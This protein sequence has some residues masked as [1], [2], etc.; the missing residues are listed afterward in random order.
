[1]K[2]RSCRNKTSC[3]DRSPPFLH[4][5]DPNT[6]RTVEDALISILSLVDFIKDG[7][8]LND[9]ATQQACHLLDIITHGAR[10]NFSGDGH[11]GKHVP[12]LVGSCSG[13]TESMIPLLT[14]SNED[15]VR[16]ALR[17]LAQTVT[18][19]S[20]QTRFA[21]LETGFFTLLPRTFYEQEVH[22]MPSSKLF[23][24]DIV[25]RFLWDSHPDYAHEILQSGQLSIDVVQQTFL[26]KFIHPIKPF[27]EYICRHRRRIPDSRKHRRFP[28]LLAKILEL[29]LLLEEMMQFVLSSSFF[30]AFTDC[31]HFYET[32][33]STSHLLQS[34]VDPLSDWWKDCPVFQK[35]RQRIVAKLCEEGVSDEIELHMRC[36]G[37]DECEHDD[38]F[39]GAVLIGLWGGNTPFFMPHW[40]IS[41]K[42][43]KLN[44]IVPESVADAD[45]AWDCTTPSNSP[46]I[47]FT[48]SRLEWDD[49][50]LHCAWASLPALNIGDRAPNFVL[51]NQD[52]QEI[53]FKDQLGDGPVVVFVCHNGTSLHD[54]RMLRGFR[55]FKK[56]FIAQNATVF[57][58]S[59]H[60]EA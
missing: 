42:H 17:L 56:L 60:T 51:K 38:V 16:S 29:S 45:R 22:L 33:R 24:M 34:V 48:L 18:W 57:R 55:F 8:N 59:A 44:R 12:T 53:S 27:L 54:K 9:I 19:G 36:E 41:R 25:H 20:K 40:T 13:F 52:G 43:R 10:N 35:R 3:S 2:T 37:Y 31:L 47:S 1:M 15:I 5:V 49:T 6:I 39:L 32:N 21:F 28:E 58:L 30:V 4:I 23:L 11:I 14:S 46:I 26:N 7:H 50:R